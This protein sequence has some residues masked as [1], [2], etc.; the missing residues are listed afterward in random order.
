MGC[1]G[2]DG[3]HGQQKKLNQEEIACL[4]CSSLPSPRLPPTSFLLRLARNGLVWSLLPC[5]SMLAWILFDW[6]ADDIVFW[7][8]CG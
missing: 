1:G 8:A 2:K 4:L 3:A 6:L 5:Q 7:L